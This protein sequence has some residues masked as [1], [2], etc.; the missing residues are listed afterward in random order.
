MLSDSTAHK[1]GCIKL[2]NMMTQFPFIE[3]IGNTDLKYIRNMTECDRNIKKKQFQLRF[4]RKLS[5]SQNSA[6]HTV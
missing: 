5:F 4:L 6:L 1:V 2:I 3:S